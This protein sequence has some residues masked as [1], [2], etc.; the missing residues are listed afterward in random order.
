[1]TPPTNPPAICATM[2]MGT[3]AQGKAPIEARAM[4]TAGLRCAPLMLFTQYTAIVT[5]NAQP[6][7]ITIQPE[8]LPLVLLRTTLATTPSPSMIRIAVPKTSARSGD[9][10]GNDASTTATS[11]DAF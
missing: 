9:M 1:M 8:L 2:Y 3:F 7:V 11:P 6:A 4:V 10:E 5:P